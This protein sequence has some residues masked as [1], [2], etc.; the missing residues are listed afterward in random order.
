LFDLRL[1]LAFV[2]L[3]TPVSAAVAQTEQSA[4]AED[5]EYPEALDVEDNTVYPEFPDAPADAP[6]ARLRIV[7]DTISEEKAKS[8]E[9]RVPFEF[10]IVAYDVQIALRGWEAKLVL[11]PRLLLLEHEFDGL[12]VGQGTEIITALTPK[13]CKAGSPLTLARFK[14]MLPKEGLE[15]VILSLAPVGKSSFDPPSP[16]YLVCRPGSDL[17][18]FDACDT[19]AVINPVHVQPEEDEISPLDSVLKPVRGR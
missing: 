13:E 18:V 7:F 10:Y 6:T 3:T 8:I 17:R 9:P 1:A 19:C 11:D 2:L 5:Q 4:A 14:A 16:G 15:D 12:N